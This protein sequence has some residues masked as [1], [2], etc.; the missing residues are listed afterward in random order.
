MRRIARFTGLGI[1]ILLLSACGSEVAPVENQGG[2]G[3]WVSLERNYSGQC[4]TAEVGGQGLYMDR[5]INS[6]AQ[7][8]RLESDALGNFFVN[9]ETGATIYA[10]SQGNLLQYGANFLF[11]APYARNIQR[12]YSGDLVRF[13]YRIDGGNY[14]M[15]NN[16]VKSCSGT[17]GEYWRVRYGY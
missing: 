9:Q 5:C 12:A 1:L 2:S 15:Y 6:P 13:V 4:L 16:S 8:F 14:C 3:K 10:T 7:N 17:Y 11:N